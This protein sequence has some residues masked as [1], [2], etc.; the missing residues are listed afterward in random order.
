MAECT[1]RGEPNGDHCC[2]VAGKVCDFLVENVGSRRF[3]CGLRL[4][5]GSWDKVHA[6]PRYQPI[7]AEWDKVG[8]ASCGEWQPKKGQCCNGW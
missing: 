2:Y 4:E 5:L 6:D 3:A 1:G 7:Q 8:I